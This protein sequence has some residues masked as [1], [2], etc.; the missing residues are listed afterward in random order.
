VIC[1]GIVIAKHLTAFE[2]TG[3]NY[4]SEDMLQPGTLEEKTTRDEYRNGCDWL[5]PMIKTCH[6]DSK[7]VPFFVCCSKNGPI[8]THILEMMIKRM[9]DLN[10]FHR[11]GPLRLPDP[12]ILT[13]GHGSRFDL[14]FLEYIDNDDHKWTTCTGRPCG[15]NKWQVGD[16]KEQN[17][18][19][20]M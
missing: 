19:F 14:P 5:F 20:N 8:T 15:T 7:D 18:A 4:L 6:F 3:I 16:S 9:D 10:L 12:F 1:A 13:D 17:G 2:A 11:Y